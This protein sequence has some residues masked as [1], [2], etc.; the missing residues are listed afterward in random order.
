MRGASPE[1]QQVFAV[2]PP[3]LAD[4]VLVSVVEPTYREADNLPLPPML[5]MWTDVFS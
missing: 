1:A 4:K 2:D 5:D 3:S